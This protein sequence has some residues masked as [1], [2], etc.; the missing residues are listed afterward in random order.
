[1]HLCNS[2]GAFPIWYLFNFV[3]EKTTTIFGK[4]RP[5]EEEL[6]CWGVYITLGNVL[7]TFTSI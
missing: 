6:T 4:Q 2:L 3:K 5:G 1:M 7:L